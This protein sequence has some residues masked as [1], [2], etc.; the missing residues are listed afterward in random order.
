MKQI[1]NISSIRQY[2]HLVWVILVL[3]LIGCSDDEQHTGSVSPNFFSL[4]MVGREISMIV[5]M[6]GEVK[7]SSPTWIESKNIQTISNGMEYTFF[8]KANLTGGDRKG[9]ILFTDGTNQAVVTIYQKGGEVYTPSENLDGIE[10]TAK[11]IKPIGGKA[12]EERKSAPFSRVWDGKTSGDVFY[13]EY[14]DDKP[15]NFPVKLDLYFGENLDFVDHIIYYPPASLLGAFGKTRVLVSKDDYATEDNQFEEVAYVD[16]GMISGSP[17]KIT[18]SK[19]VKGV[20]TVRLSVEEGGND[21]VGAMEIEVYTKNLT[22]FDP[23]ELF[24]DVTCSEL[25]TGIGEAEIE[26]YPY[27]FFKNIA[28]HMLKNT[29]PQEFRIGEYKA[30]QH[31]DK[32]SKTNK[33]TTYSL[34]DN[35]TGI[36]VREDETLIVMVGDMNNETISL[37]IT[38]WDG[39]KEQRDGF[40]TYKTFLL[41]PGINRLEHCP[42]GLAYIMYHT[43]NFK[44]AKPV[45][46]HIAS[47]IVNGYYDSSKHRPEQWRELLAAASNKHFDV[48]GKYAHIVFPRVNLQSV[49]DGQAWLDFYD[50]LVYEEQKF[51]GLEKYD[52]M[53][54]NRMLFSVIYSDAYMYS[55]SYHTGYSK[56]TMANLC[57]LTKIKTDNWGLAHEVGHS[58]QT[59]PGLKWHGMTEV[60]NNI[61][62]MYIQRITSRESRLLKQNKYAPAMTQA[63][64]EKRPFIMLGTTTP[65]GA[66]D[67]FYQ[68]APFWQLQLYMEYVLGKTEFYKDV[69][70]AVRIETDKDLKTQSGEIQCDFAYKCC[71]ASGLDLTDFFEKWGFFR[72]MKPYPIDDYLKADY[73]VTQ[74]Y[75]DKIKEDIAVLHLPKPKHRFEYITELSGTIYKETNAQIQ[76]GRATRSGDTFTMNGWKNVVAFEV[77]DSLGKLLYVSPEQVFTANGIPERVIVK[78]VAADGTSLNVAFN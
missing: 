51:M 65:G 26:A 74:A 34:L 70:E 31:P 17:Q 32:Q 38:D 68:L 75:I 10:M 44:V 61:L 35:P 30:W 41:Q 60:T 45:K 21:E 64:A 6:G 18:I 52:K 8:V 19:E 23:T 25:K 48:I 71:M 22:D 40:G 14:T 47:G 59:R 2:S 15:A 3:L 4:E 1:T 58:N 43:D 9:E 24:T 66:T 7:T 76:R 72:A 20:K 46:V 67:V 78:A 36:A 73:E 28:R 56:G 62:S 42:K 13:T 27:A 12:S 16:L 37:R 11:Y 33:T 50:S 57:D 54:N 5:K 77:Y 29:Y 55:T 53:F 63:F 49:H 69:Y 39:E